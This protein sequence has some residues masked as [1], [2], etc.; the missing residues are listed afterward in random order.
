MVQGSREE[1]SHKMTRSVGFYGSIGPTQ[2]HIFDPRAGRT[3]APALLKPS[4]GLGAIGFRLVLTCLGLG[5]IEIYWIL[6]ILRRS[7]LRPQIQKNDNWR[8]METHQNSAVCFGT[9]FH[10]PVVGEGCAAFKKGAS[11]RPWTCWSLPGAQ[12]AE[13][14]RNDPKC[15]PIFT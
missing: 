9:C 10:H 2:A 6:L 12:C 15:H 3:E 4:L 8:N 14:S 1:T 11:V 13:L 7:F 5:T